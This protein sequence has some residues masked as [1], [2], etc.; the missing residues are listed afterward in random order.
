MFDEEHTQE[1]VARVH[2]RCSRCGGSGLVMRNDPDWRPLREPSTREQRRLHEGTRLVEVDCPTCKGNG[3]SHAT[4]G[5]FTTERDKAD[6]LMPDNVPLR[7][8]SIGNRR[9]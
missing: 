2:H 8:V 1:F 5:G 4:I 3:I 6:W 9:T 7:G